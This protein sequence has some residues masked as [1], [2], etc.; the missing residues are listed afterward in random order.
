MLSFLARN[1]IKGTRQMTRTPKRFGTRSFVVAPEPRFDPNPQIVLDDNV[2]NLA[3]YV[4]IISSELG[5]VSG[6][7]GIAVIG[8][9]SGGKSTFIDGVIGVDLTY[10]KDGLGT[11]RVTRYQVIHSDEIAGK[12]GYGSW[13]YDMELFKRKL[14]EENRGDFDKTD[15]EVTI[16]TPFCQD[17]YITDT[18][19]YFI[20]SGIG[21]DSQSGEL[22]LADKVIK[23]IRPM[24]EDENTAKVIVKS[25]LVDNE[26]CKA[27]EQVK[28]ARQY[29]NSIIILTRGDQKAGSQQGREKLRS[30]L[31][32]PDPE[33]SLSSLMPVFAVC[34]RT[35]NDIAIGMTIEEKVEWEQ[36]F[37]EENGMSDLPVGIPA[38][39]NRMHSELLAKSI[40]QLP[41]MEVAIDEEITKLEQK[42]SRIGKLSTGEDMT[43]KLAYDAKEI[44]AIMNRNSPER[45][46]IDDTIREEN[47]ALI[48]EIVDEGFLQAFGPEWLVPLS[49]KGTSV[50][51]TR[52]V[53]D[54]YRIIHY[55]CDVD[56]TDYNHWLDT[57][58]N[59]QLMTLTTNEEITKG[60]YANAKMS[61]YGTMFGF[62]FDD[63]RMPGKKPL[64]SR[65]QKL[66]W[67][68][69]YQ[70]AIDIITKDLGI[71]ERC[72][73]NTV[74][75]YLDEIDRFRPENA[76]EECFEFFSIVFDGIG[77]RTKTNELASILDNLVV[78]EKNPHIEINKASNIL[79]NVYERDVEFVNDDSGE[80]YTR[81]WTKHSGI[82]F[83]DEKFPVLKPFYGPTWTYVS[84]EIL[85]DRLCEHY[86]QTIHQ[87]VSDPLV[88]DFLEDIMNHSRNFN[89]SEIEQKLTAKVDRLTYYKTVL[90]RLKTVAE[91]YENSEK[92]RREEVAIILQK[93]KE[94]DDRKKELKNIMNGDMDDYD[95][96]SRSRP[97]HKRHAKSRRSKD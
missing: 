23:K 31:T 75:T 76:S 62:Q 58:R 6:S 88:T 25:A 94:E 5:L 30:D 61:L 81:D 72:R 1:T 27:L 9:Q 53:N 67:F 28:D 68:R 93:K 47:G 33:K 63:I 18:P 95:D 57:H 50:P 46:E 42:K 48:R 16:K 86:G 12:I 66:R 20:S 29:H 96:E 83:R 55:N 59:G 60:R 92:Q 52:D 54:C 78:K 34:Q 41:K 36:K 3:R 22:S 21:Y 49:E 45:I 89:S 11:K 56:E 64:K 82:I 44:M 2:S 17:L 4:P 77:E 84:K 79:A 13:I 32:D 70:K 85:I 37:W 8:D 71:S 19:G 15:L 65:T 90:Q 14:V 91:E 10:K 38:V 24:I 97:R 7:N 35:D 69:K 40:P 87:Q 73:K 80:N 26:R 43:R 39:R 74:D 51:D